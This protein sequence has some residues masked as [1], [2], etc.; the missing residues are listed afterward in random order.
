MEYTL[1][2]EEASEYAHAFLLY[3]SLRYLRS[4]RHE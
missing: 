4:R 3:K 2:D 1:S